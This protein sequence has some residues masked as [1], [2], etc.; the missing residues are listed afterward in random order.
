MRW[1]RRD[2]VCPLSVESREIGS[3]HLQRVQQKPV[4]PFFAIRN[5]IMSTESSTLSNVLAAP[6]GKWDL[7]IPDGAKITFRCNNTSL[8]HGANNGVIVHTSYDYTCS[9]F[10]LAGLGNCSLDKLQIC[11]MVQSWRVEVWHS[12]KQSRWDP[13]PDDDLPSLKSHLV[14]MYCSPRQWSYL[15]R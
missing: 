4:R 7:E 8:Q 6:F 2:L 15:W 9:T 12:D 10:G 11:Q 5:W 14:A 1:D 13:T 3:L